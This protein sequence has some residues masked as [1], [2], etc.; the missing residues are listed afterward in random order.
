MPVFSAAS[1]PSPGDAASR[2][3]RYVAETAI[4]IGKVRLKNS[5]QRLVRRGA[6]R[7]Q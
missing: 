5:A 6:A 1:W 4:V 7:R 2:P 3:V